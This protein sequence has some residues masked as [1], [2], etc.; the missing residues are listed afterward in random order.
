[1]EASA[2]ALFAPQA[3]GSR[4]G[5]A[6][7]QEILGTWFRVS[8][9]RGRHHPAKNPRHHRSRGRSRPRPGAGRIH[10]RRLLAPRSAGHRAAASSGILVKIGEADDAPAHGWLTKRGDDRILRGVGGG[11][12]LSATSRPKK[13]GRIDQ[14]PAVRA[15]DR[16]A[17]LRP[18]RVPDRLLAK[19]RDLR[20]VRR[21][22]R[23]ARGAGLRG[24]EEQQLLTG[25]LDR[26]RRWSPRAG[27]AAQFAG[28]CGCCCGGK[29]RHAARLLQLRTPWSK[30][31]LR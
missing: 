10:G 1:M 27:G 17:G 4:S 12:A 11:F 30:P 5:V 26:E 7:R 20:C 24:T 8:A 13:C 18:H 28:H 21:I 25:L 16:R 22:H 3:P 6:Y 23:R 14:P 15:E 29:R 19:T 2:A 9:L 31:P